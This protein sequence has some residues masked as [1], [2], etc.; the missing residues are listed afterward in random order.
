MLGARIDAHRER[1]LVGIRVAIHHE[2]EIEGIELM[3]L[4]GQTDQPPGMGGHEIDLIRRREL[5][6]ADQIAFV[7]PSFVI[8]NHHAFT[9][10]DRGEGIGNRIEP[11]ALRSVS[12]GGVAQ[13]S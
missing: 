11:N 2:R 5:G 4:H 9:I 10:S 3:P 7:F 13:G 8:H 6:S 1:G 12:G